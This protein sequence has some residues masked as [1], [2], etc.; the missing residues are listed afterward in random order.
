MKKILLLSI[1]SCILI[2]VNAQKPQG[3]GSAGNASLNIG[4]LYGKVLS[5]K[6]GKALKGATVQLLDSVYNKNTHKVSEK[7][8]KI[9]VSENNG[10]FSLENVPLIGNFTLRVSSEGYKVMNTN[11]NF[12][13]R[14]P[15]SAAAAQKPDIASLMSHAE[16]DLGN[17]KLDIDAGYLGTV[18]VT[19]D[20]K[21]QM[22]LGLDKKVYNVSQDLLSNGQTAQDL[23]KNIPS[24]NIDIDGNVTIRNSTPTLFVDGRPTTLTLDEI[25]S[26]VIDKVEV[27]TNPSA[28]YDASGTGGILNIILKKNKKNGYNGGLRAGV[29]KWGRLNGGGDFSYKKEKLNISLMANY[30]GR[31]DK[32][33]GNTNRLAYDD[34]NVISNSDMNSIRKGS[35]FF[36]RG[37]LDYDL[38]IRNTVSL[39][40]TK[41]HGTFKN[42]EADKIDSLLQTSADAFSQSERQT[43]S[44]A[45]FNGWNGQLSY[46]HSFPKSGH[47]L[48]A[49]LNYMSGN[50]SSNSNI[51]SNTYEPGTT[52]L[53]YPE[54]KQIGNGSGFMHFF[55][56]QLDYENPISEKTKVEAGLR[57]AIQDF[58]TT[59]L[60][61]IY[62][63][64]LDSYV[65]SSASSSNYKNKTTNLAG[66]V[67]F[68]SQIGSMFSYQLGLRAESY[69]YTGN[70]LSF[71]NSTDSI[72]FKENYP[73][74]FF[75]SIYLTY[76]LDQLQSLQLNYS[77]KVQR[78]SFF[79]MIPAY[80]FSDPQN[81]TVGNANLKPEYTSSFEFSYDNNY[82]PNADFLATLYLRYTKDMIARYMY[83]DIDRNTTVTNPTDSL[84]Y[85]SYTNADYSYAYGLEL[86]NRMPITKWWNVIMNLSLFDSKIHTSSNETTL[87]VDNSILAW[88]GKLSNTFI[89]SKG[90]SFELNGQYQSKTVVPQNSSTTTAGGRGMGSNTQASSQGYILPA[91]NIDAAIRRDWNLKNNQILSLTFSASDIFKTNKYKTST[92]SAGLYDQTSWRLR[93]PQMFRLSLSYRFGKMNLSKQK[94]SQ[95]DTGASS[96]MDN[97]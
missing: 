51:Y 10:D 35:F 88:T 75:P 71:I 77:R 38:D 97:M 49:D 94:K 5:N 31:K 74:Q 65:F 83:K 6:T 73:I 82:K 56:G 93:D 16:Q 8:L 33:T 26:D 25:P 67:T 89:L 27:I 48:T 63:N 84:F 24:V 42:D 1:L 80:N 44:N 45:S 9:V 47:D 50:S 46:K 62:S 13:M 95:Q 11:L 69:K 68:S 55:T 18:V 78:P 23:M 3:I 29:D 91:Y 21:Q 7:V 40:G 76:K 64:T 14:R 57:A 12:G 86:T 39:Y 52:T 22:E 59:D 85:L 79:Q 41:I 28:K 19:T 61:S 37:G 34:P 36:L 54:S 32:E 66:Y 2:S 30:N 4:H 70:M 92:S 53:L 43:N 72:N 90:L 87:S 96:L 17:I 81:P 15:T 58:K 20:K 60:E